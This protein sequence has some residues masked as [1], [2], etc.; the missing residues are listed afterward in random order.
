MK[1][2]NAT[3][4]DVESM[5][6]LIEVYANREVVLPRSLLSI[7]QHLQCMYVV[8][9]ESKVVGVAGLHILGKDIA[10]VRSLVVDPIYQH[11][12]IGH[13]L[14]K[15]II[16]ESTELGVGRLISLTYQVDFFAK[17]GFNIVE[18]ETLPEKVWTDCINCP[19]VN[20]CDEVAMIK[21]LT[22][23]SKTKL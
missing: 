10:E 11:K 12:G 3:I 20:E 15:H 19:K 6:Q 8:K 17:C 23:K 5:H 7:Y 18:K 4:A 2:F 16:M 13:M 1:I 21:Y 22:E 9:D 14:V